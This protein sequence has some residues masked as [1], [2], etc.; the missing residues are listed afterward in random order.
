R[1]GET[2]EDGIGQHCLHRPVQLAA[3]GAMA[4]IYED[5]DLAYRPAGPGLK[6]PDKRVEVCHI[7]PAELVDERT[8]EARLG[9]AK[10]AHQVVAAAGAIDGLARLGEDPL[11]LFVQLVTVGDDGHAP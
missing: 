1:A 8:Q 4:L 11:N 10:L 2:D 7:P 9:L 3:L 5:K 6:L